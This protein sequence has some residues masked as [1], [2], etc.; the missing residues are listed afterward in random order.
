MK[1]SGKTFPV[2]DYCP[3]QQATVNRGNG[4]GNENGNGIGNGKGSSKLQASAINCT[5]SKFM[6]GIYGP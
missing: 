2:I 4:T 3:F 5:Q 1:R 6:V